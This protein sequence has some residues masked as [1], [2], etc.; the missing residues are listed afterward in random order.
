MGTDFPLRFQFKGQ[1]N[2]AQGPDI[3]DA[4]CDALLQQGFATIEK[5]D[6]VFHRMTRGQMTARFLDV[7]EE[8]GEDANVVLR[9]LLDGEPRTVVARESGEEITGRVEYDE[10]RLVAAMQFELPASTVELAPIDGY[11][12]CEQVVSMNKALLTRL[13]PEAEGKWLFTR[14]QLARSFRMSRFSRLQLL[15]QG[16][17]NYRLTRTQIFGDGAKLGHVYFS[18]QPA[19]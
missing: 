6:L 18:L 2:Y 19:A 12:N 11:S 10:D 9:C 5:L 7:G 1:R 16:H 13:L 8:P 4:L 15:F 14:L 3:H 17:S